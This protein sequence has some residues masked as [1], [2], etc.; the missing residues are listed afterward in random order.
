ML[1][2]LLFAARIVRKQKSIIKQDTAQQV[3]NIV[4]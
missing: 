4:P 1:F 2:C 3:T